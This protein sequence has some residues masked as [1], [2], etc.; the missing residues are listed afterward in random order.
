[1][2]TVSALCRRAA[3][4]LMAVVLIV[5]VYSGVA[6]EAAEELDAKITVSYDLQ[7]DFD[8]IFNCKI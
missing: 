3:V 2:T 8:M 1:M 7:E 5:G 6:V 4:C